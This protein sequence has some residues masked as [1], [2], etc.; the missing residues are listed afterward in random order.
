MS[1][2]GHQA[3]VLP[4]DHDEEWNDATG[5]VYWLP[6]ISPNLQAT[7]RWESQQT[8]GCYWGSKWARGL[9]IK[10]YHL[11]FQSSEQMRPMRWNDGYIA[12]FYSLI[13]FN[14]YQTSYEN[15]EYIIRQGARGDTFFIISKGRVSRGRG[16]FN[17]FRMFWLF[18]RYFSECTSFFASF[19]ENTSYFLMNFHDFRWKLL[20]NLERTRSRDS[21]VPYTGVTFLVK[22]HSKGTGYNLFIL[23]RF[24]TNFLVYSFR[25]FG[26][27]SLF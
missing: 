20:W 15:G 16:W 26:G 24:F 4:N 10:K 7:L 25:K 27:F 12:L 23:F 19:S 11:A 18:I 1:S 5:G 8:G 9:E 17:Y 13:S 3:S 14:V 2:L 21:C 6:E 22:R